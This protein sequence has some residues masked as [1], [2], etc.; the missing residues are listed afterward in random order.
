MIAD[1]DDELLEIINE[2]GSNT[3]IYKTREYIHKNRLF[4]NETTIFIIN[5]DNLLL[6][7]RSHNKRIYPLML[8]AA[9]GHV[10]KGE[11]IKQSALKE[12]E[13]EVGLKIKENDMKYI[14]T[15]KKYGEKQNCFQNVFYVYTDKR[16][17]DL[18]KQDNEV[19]E[20]IYMNINEFL[21][22]CKDKYSDVMYNYYEEKVLFDK[23][24]KIVKEGALV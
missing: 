14:M 10:I 19:E 16:L 1:K 15:F 18:K 9:G 11:T 17:D 8:C 13:E 21:D 6:E 5:G 3:G 4:H 24:E 7:R 22:K 20:L 2:D 23:L 12:I